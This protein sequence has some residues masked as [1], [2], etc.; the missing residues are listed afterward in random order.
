MEAEGSHHTSLGRAA[1][2]TCFARR[3]HAAFAGVRDHT[4]FVVFAIVVGC[5]RSVAAVGVFVNLQANQTWVT[6]FLKVVTGVAFFLGGDLTEA[7]LVGCGK[8]FHGRRTLWSFGVTRLTTVRGLCR[9][10]RA[11]EVAFAEVVAVTDVACVLGGCRT[12]A[13]AVDRQAA[14]VALAGWSRWIAGFVTS[15]CRTRQTC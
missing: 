10:S 9:R 6:K 7:S 13:L 4:C 11:Y 1:T 12:E 15:R 2:F 8:A 14:F 3:R 5:A